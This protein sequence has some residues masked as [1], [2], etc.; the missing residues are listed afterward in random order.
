MLRLMLPGLA[1]LGR[2]ERGTPDKAQVNIS[3]RRRY[4]RNAQ[5]QD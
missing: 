3:V 5:K 2:Y 4:L 1:Q